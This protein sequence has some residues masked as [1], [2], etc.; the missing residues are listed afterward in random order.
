[1]YNSIVPLG[2]KRL[3]L[4][5]DPQKGIGCTIKNAA[6]HIFVNKILEDGPIAETG[7]LRPGQWLQIKLLCSYVNDVNTG[8]TTVSMTS[9]IFVA[10][11]NYRHYKLFPIVLCE[12]YSAYPIN[13]NEILCVNSDHNLQLWHTY[14][15]VVMNSSRH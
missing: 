13:A 11:S 4:F 8:G 1:M 15:S 7:I 2:V 3:T 5:K 6:G 12:V 9:P 14:P 10:I